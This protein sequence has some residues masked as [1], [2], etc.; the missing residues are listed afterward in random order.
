MLKNRILSEIIR[1]WWVLAFML[2]C[3][4]LFEHSLESRQAQRQQLYEQW[5][6]LQGEKEKELSKQ[7]DLQLQINSQSDPAW[8]E[9]LLIKVLGLVPENQ[10]K[11]FFKS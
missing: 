1:S 4:A 3:L 10:V 7:T 9:L 6:Q 5:T 8:I 11:F 2:I